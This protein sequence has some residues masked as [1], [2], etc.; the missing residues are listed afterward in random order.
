MKHSQNTNI[1]RLKAL[2]NYISWFEIP[3]YN[4]ERALAFYNDIY[5]MQM[6]TSEGNGYLMAYFPAKSGIGGAIV[7]GDGCIP[8]NTGP[9]LY[10]NG[11]PDLSSVLSKIDHAG[12]RVVMPKTLISED[13]G[14]FALFID[15]EGNRLALHSNK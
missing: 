15:T 5:S 14:Y 9:L 6:E 1:L 8:S 3:A 2:K 7:C 11:G 13:A 10:L 4:F 12:G